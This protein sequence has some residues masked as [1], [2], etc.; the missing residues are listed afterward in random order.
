LAHLSDQ[1]KQEIVSGQR[2]F[3]HIP[4]APPTAPVSQTQQPTP[5]PASTAPASQTPQPAPAPAAPTQQAAAPQPAVPA[6]P[7]APASEAPTQ[8]PAPAYAQPTPAPQP[9]F[10]PPPASTATGDR[11]NI[12]F[13][14]A[15]Y[16]TVDLTT[17]PLTL[18]MPLSLGDQIGIT[19]VAVGEGRSSVV[20][21]L[22]TVLNP[23][24]T[25][26]LTPGETEVIGVN[27]STTGQDYAWF[28]AQAQAGN[29][30]AEYGLGH[31]YQYGLGVPQNTSQAVY[32]YRQAAAQNYLDAQTQLSRLGY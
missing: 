5:A 31:M 1:V 17:S 30:T 11:I 14:G 15:F 9:E 8:Q 28:Q 23:V 4:V 18:D 10:T 24:E 16:E 20:V 32:W 2:K 29:P 12:S 26:P 27:H 19:C 22:A 21:D 13:N 3:Y 25:R 7:P 6:T